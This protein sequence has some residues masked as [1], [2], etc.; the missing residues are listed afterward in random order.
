MSDPFVPRVGGIL[1]VVSTEAIA[2]I[3]R[4]DYGMYE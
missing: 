3:E 4:P 1:P 2:P